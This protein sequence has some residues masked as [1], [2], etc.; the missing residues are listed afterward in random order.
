MVGPCSCSDLVSCSND[1]SSPS[2]KSLTCHSHHSRRLPQQDAE[3]HDRRRARCLD[4]AALRDPTRK[5]EVAGA[6]EPAG[7]GPRLGGPMIVWE[8]FPDRM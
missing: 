3:H 8:P 4:G 7:E 5:E 1:L 6:H 2:H